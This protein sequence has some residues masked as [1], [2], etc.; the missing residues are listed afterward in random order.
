MDRQLFEDRLAAF[1]VAKIDRVEID[2]AVCDAQRGCVGKVFEGHRLRQGVDAVLH[3]ADV[4]EQ[5]RHLPEYP[6]RHA[7]N[8]QHQCNGNGDG[9]EADGALLPGHDRYAADA[10]E[11]QCIERLQAH[12]ELG[13]QPHLP[14]DGVE[15]ADHGLAGVELFVAGVG[16][17]LQGLDVGVGVDDAAGH[18]GA[19]IGLRHRDAAQ[20]GHEDAQQADVPHKPDHQRRNQPRLGLTDQHDCAHEINGDIDENVEHLDHRFTD[21]QRGLHHLLRQAPGELFLEK[22]QALVQQHVVHAPAPDHRIVAEHGLVSDQRLHEDGQRIGDDDQT[23][24]RQQAHAVRLPQR[25]GVCGAQPV[26]QGAEKAHEGDFDHRHGCGHRR[27]QRQPWQQ[28]ARKIKNEAA[29]RRGRG[30]QPGVVGQRRQRVNAGFE[31]AEEHG[32]RLRKWGRSVGGFAPAGEPM[33][34]SVRRRYGSTAPW[35]TTMRSWREISLTGAVECAGKAW[36]S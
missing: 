28:R 3:G 10:G 9:A 2:G 32:G 23:A 17:Q 14:V 13:H 7:A 20:P 1:F 5:R 33:G 15:K 29:Q 19:R 21:G 24:H 4:F 11:Q 18:V 22:G 30:L 12:G 25:L 6:V 35:C 31:K 16:K 36:A 27:H 8:A 34:R 26:D